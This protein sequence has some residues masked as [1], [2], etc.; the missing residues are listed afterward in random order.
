M[1]RLGQEV[2]FAE[3]ASRD[4]GLISF[5]CEGELRGVG[6]REGFEKLQFNSDRLV[7]KALRQRHQPCADF[8]VAV[9]RIDRAEDN[10]DPVFMG[11]IEFCPIKIVIKTAVKIF[12]ENQ[13]S[14]TLMLRT[15]NGTK[16]L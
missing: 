5:R 15:R 16:R 2:F 6:G 10:S 11:L 3:H 14:S 13:P 9:P 8:I 12:S 4:P 1:D 7:R